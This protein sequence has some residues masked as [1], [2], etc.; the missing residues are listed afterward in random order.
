MRLIHRNITPSDQAEVRLVNKF[1]E[2]VLQLIDVCGF[3]KE[4]LA[5]DTGLRDNVSQVLLFS[6]LLKDVPWDLSHD[7]G[8]ISSL[9]VP[10]ATTPMV[11]SFKGIEGL[12]ENLVVTETLDVGHE[13]N[14]TGIS[15]PLVEI[16]FL[17][18]SL[19]RHRLLV[20][21]CCVFKTRLIFWRNLIQEFGLFT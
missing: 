20:I 2:G 7:A 13:S 3:V 11:I 17:N 5:N 6:P 16:L 9:V 4:E 12:L 1:L 19:E 10:I 21:S 18:I 15:F 14:S 8:T